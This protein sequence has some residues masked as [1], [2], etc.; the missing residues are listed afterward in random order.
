MTMPEPSPL[1]RFGI[2]HLLGLTAALAV[3]MA[4]SKTS[5]DQLQTTLDSSSNQLRTDEDLMRTARWFAFVGG[6]IFGVHLFVAGCLLIWSKTREAWQLQP[7]HILAVMGVWSITN[8]LYALPLY[9]L[10]YGIVPLVCFG[11]QIAIANWARRNPASRYWQIYF[12]LL[13]ATLAIE[14]VSTMRLVVGPQ[15]L[16]DSS[17]PMRFVSVIGGLIFIASLIYLGMA[18]V[19]DLRS[20]PPRHWSHWWGL[21]A[22]CVSTLLIYGQ[23][24]WNMYA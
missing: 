1:P 17:L 19:Q 15:F 16:T 24:I 22:T 18:I 2:R 7:G 6:S 8:H 23:V 5:L 13:M 21:T 20:S 9:G 3:A 4:L 12:L 10:W 14:W 11:P